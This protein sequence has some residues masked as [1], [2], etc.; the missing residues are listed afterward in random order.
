M[1]ISTPLSSFTKLPK[2]AVTGLLL[3]DKPQGLTSNGALQRVKRLYNAKKAGHTGSLDPLAS[4][5]LPICFGEAT[6]FSQFLLTADKRYLVT[7]T[8][9]I[10]TTTDDSEGEVIET[11]P[12]AGISLDKVEQVLLQFQGTFEQVPPM[13]SAIKHQGQPLY[14]L[15]RQGITIE[16]KSRQVTVHSM[17]LIKFDGKLLT[18]D[19]RC[20][21]GTYVRTLAGDIGKAL[22]CGA[23]ISA[24]RRLEVNAYHE[25]DMVAME[26]LE[27][28]A[29]QQNYPKLDSWLIPI[30][31]IFVDLPTV[32]LTAAMIYYMKQG[33]PVLVS[34]APTR[35]LVKLQSKE[36]KFLGLGEIT[37][38]GK[39]APHRMVK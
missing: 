29:V 23:H 4:G 2:R 18:L 10:T 9:G 19:I 31:S 25:R 37:D 6:K 11:K 1:I 5:M 34:G 13:Y 7:C 39:V 12:C 20:S 16:R 35:G 28:L 30:E 15:A 3:L 21:K 14:A 36:Q 32:S 22:G 17:Q 24:L 38:D 26:T 27:Q 8:L 33:Q